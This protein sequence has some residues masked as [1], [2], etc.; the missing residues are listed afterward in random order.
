MR[1]LL[2]CPGSVNS[3]EHHAAQTIH[4]K[5][6][7][8]QGGGSYQHDQCTLLQLLRSWPG[9]VFH[10]LVV[11]FFQIKCQ[12]FHRESLYATWLEVAFSGL[13][14]RHSR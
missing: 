1:P 14:F 7:D 4:Q 10:Q 3:F 11:A 13:F 12:F 5:N 6:E 9:D 2:R 8:S